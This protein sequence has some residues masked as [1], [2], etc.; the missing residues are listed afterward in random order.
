[1]STDCTIALEVKAMGQEDWRH[2]AIVSPMRNP[3]L[4]AFLFGVENEDPF[5]SEKLFPKPFAPNRGLPDN[6][7]DVTKERIFASGAINRT[8]ELHHVTWI[9]LE[10]WGA[11]DKETFLGPTIVSRVDHGEYD[12]VVTNHPD[13]ARGE[14]IVIMSE[15]PVTFRGML[16]AANNLS[17]DWHGMIDMLAMLH[18]DGEARMIAW[19]DQP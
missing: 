1:M 18:K 6:A 13:Q 11:L 16:V 17:H 7:S 10:E 4:F 5:G 3:F 12:I 8:N 14:E 2:V 15:Y 19:F 9:S